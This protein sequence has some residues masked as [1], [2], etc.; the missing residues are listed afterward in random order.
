MKRS[1]LLLTVMLALMMIFCSCAK[2]EKYT[3][4]IHDRIHKNFSDIGSYTAKCKITIHSQKNTVYSVILNYDKKDKMY[5]MTYD[6]IVITAKGDEARIEKNGSALKTRSSSDYMPMFINQFFYYYYSGEESS[7]NV[8]KIK[9]FGTTTLE[10]QLGEG[11]KN[12]FSQ[13]VWIDNQTAMPVKAEIYREDGSIYM[14]IVYK[15]FV[16]K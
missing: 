10:A 5:K 7:L 3:E 2:S 11:D 9:N 13:K 15:T 6:D 12:A 14:E 1:R 8:S 4:T 16:F